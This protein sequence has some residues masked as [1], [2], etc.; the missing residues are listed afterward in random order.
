[1]MVS[2]LIL[3]VFVIPRETRRQ[4]RN[5]LIA[6]GINVDLEDDPNDPLP[7]R[8]NYMEPVPQPFWIRWWL[9]HFLPP[10]LA[11]FVG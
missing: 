10:T 7:Y 6:R 5:A 11:V 8:M 1:M 3:G 9:E 2:A 4:A